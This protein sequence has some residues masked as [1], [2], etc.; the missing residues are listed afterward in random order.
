MVVLKPF[1]F[2]PGR[3]SCNSMLILIDRDWSSVRA[4]DKTAPSAGVLTLDVS[5]FVVSGGEAV[6]S[7]NGVVC[8]LPYTA[9]ALVKAVPAKPG[10]LAVPLC[11]IVPQ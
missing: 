11:I 8:W 3:L 4:C 2:A 5:D 7:D 1:T 9:S 10:N 6:L